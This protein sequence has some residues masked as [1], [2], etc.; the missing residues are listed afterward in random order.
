MTADAGR[1]ARSACP[2][3]GPDFD[4]VNDVLGIH[5]RSRRRAALA[6]A[7][8]WFGLVDHLGARNDEALISFS[9]RRGPRAGVG[10]G[11]APGRCCPRTGR[12]AEIDRVD[13]RGRRHRPA[14]PPSRCCAQH[15]DCWWSGCGSRGRAT[16]ALEAVE[17]QGR[18]TRRSVAAM[19]R[20]RG[21]RRR[22][23]RSRGADDQPA[24]GVLRRTGRHQAG[25]GPLLPGRGASPSWRWPRGAPPSCSASRTAPLASRSSRSGC[26][27][28]RRRGCRR[29][30]SPPPTAPRPTLSCWPTWPTW[31]G[32]ST[33]GCLGFHV[34]PTHWDDMDHADELRIDLDP[35]PGVDLRD[36]PGGR[37]AARV[38]L[39][40]ELGVSLVPE[41][42]GQPGRPRVRATATTVGLRTRC[43]PP[44]WR[45]PASWSADEGDLVTAAWWKEERGERVFI[46]FNQNAPHK[47]VFGAWSVRARPAANVSAPF[48]GTSSTTIHPDD[49]T[50]V[51]V[52]ERLARAWRSVG[53]DVR[54]SRSRSSRCSRCTSRIGPRGCSMRPGRPSTRRCRTSRPGWH[55][56]GPV[57]RR[58]S[59]APRAAGSRA[60]V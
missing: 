53:R 36:D 28:A 31:R 54:R 26:R 44:P 4:A 42:H 1:Q 29:R 60:C 14:H 30:W 15:R 52:P 7:S 16:R 38:E 3:C 27:P 18:P 37:P 39:L 2:R 19:A 32:R 25:S 24:E 20:V 46:D 50:I 41:D 59:T 57:A 45:W 51:T 13:R 23:R 49:L 34:W 33:S 56:A 48:R 6:A 22:G 35:S 12:P 58:S 21:G 55:P 43:A 10:A 17:R 47:T 5:G 9:L 40:A 8:P 11:R